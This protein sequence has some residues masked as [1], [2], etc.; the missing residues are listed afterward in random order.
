M[1]ACL[2]FS[3]RLRTQLA[4]VSHRVCWVSYMPVVVGLDAAHEHQ[5]GKSS[6]CQAQMV[7]YHN[8]N[9]SIELEVVAIS[10]QRVW[11]S[12]DVIEVR[13]RLQEAPT[14]GLT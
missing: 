5:G 3:T 1:S 6:H 2:Y 14:R 7:W 13:D 11:T 12:L 9:S 8:R 10:C 4:S